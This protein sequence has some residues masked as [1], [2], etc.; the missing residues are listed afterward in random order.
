[1]Q[2]R[3]VDSFDWS[4]HIPVDRAVL[5]FIIG[6]GQ[7]LLIHKLRGLGMGKVNGPGG[8]LESGETPFDAAVRETQEEVGL[9]PARLRHAGELSF[10]FMDGYSLDCSVITAA[11]SA[12]TP[13]KTAE[14]DP[15]WCPL[16]RIPYDLMWEDDRLW[17]P[18]ML[19]GTHFRGRFIFDGDRMLDHRLLTGADAT[20]N[21]A[22]LARK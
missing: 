4:T 11:A 5:C 7:I 13:V 12:G 14:A 8:R 18:H 19:E 17:I 21:E 1:M 20:L 22:D 3:T 15:F 16:D 2:A 6:N 10:V 9:T